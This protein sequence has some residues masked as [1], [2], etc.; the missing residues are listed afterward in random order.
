MSYTLIPSEYADVIK[1]KP[2]LFPTFEKKTL[3]FFMIGVREIDEEEIGKKIS[4]ISAS[5][6]VSGDSSESFKT[7]EM[8]VLNSG[9]NANQYVELN[10]KVPLN[11]SFDPVVDVFLWDC[12]KQEPNSFL[13]YGSLPFKEIPFLKYSKHP[14]DD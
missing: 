6:D 3:S 1:P 5:L 14:S 9:C 8:K 12:S 10:I 2:N 4:K 13:G 7:E 11:K